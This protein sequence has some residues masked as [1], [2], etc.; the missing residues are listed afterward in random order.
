MS[1]TIPEQ[2]WQL[3]TLGVAHSCF[4]EKFAVPRQP[5]LVPSALTCIELSA[6]YNRPE[7]VAGLEDFSH[8]WISFVFHHNLSQGWKPKVRPPR[9]GGN[10]KV[11]VFA[12]RSSFRPNGLGLSVVKLES[13]DLTAGVKI[14]VSGADLVNGTPIVDIKPYIPWVDSQP[15][16]TAAWVPGP[17]ESFPVTFSAAAKTALTKLAKAAELTQLITE[18]LAQNPRPAY[19]TLDPT[20]VYA[21]YLA[22]LNVSFSYQP[23]AS[24]RVVAIEERLN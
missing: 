14:W 22:N 7:M 16:A 4:P 8:L 5:S 9:L 13:L 20:R 23:D 17:P 12:S 6:P 2:S 24:L 3:A 19:Q 15:E 21:M 18:V 1:A 11:G 10:K